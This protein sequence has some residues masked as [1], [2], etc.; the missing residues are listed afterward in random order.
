M[1]IGKG[2]RMNTDE[3]GS[4][5][6]AGRT[7]TGLLT[8]LALILP[9]EARVP[10]LRVFSLQITSVEVL[11]Y[12]A[13]LVW[14]I[15]WVAGRW[16]S[17]TVCHTCVGVFALV[18]LISALLAPFE[19]AAALKFALRSLG[20]CA[21]FYAAADLSGSLRLARRHVAAII[22]GASISAAAGCAEILSPRVAG[23]LG[24]FKTQPS[25]VGGYLR[26]SGTFQYANIGAMY[27]EAAVPLI[28]SAAFAAATG[29]GRRRTPWPLIAAMA[30][31]VEAILLSMSRAAELVS[32]VLLL[33]ILL[34]ARRVAAVPR[35][36]VL[37]C[38]LAL[39]LPL[40]CHLVLGPAFRLRLTTSEQSSWY[41]AAYSGNFG[42]MEMHPGQTM[43]LPVRIR[44]LGAMSWPSS[45]PRRITLSY[46][47][48]D[49]RRGG[50]IVWDGLRTPLPGDVA[51]GE[52]VALNARIQ[53]PELSGSCVLHLDLAQEG[54]TW[55][56]L[57][58][59]PS[60]EIPISLQGPASESMKSPEDFPL[61]RPASIQTPARRGLWRAALRMWETHPVFGVGPDNFRL[62]RGRFQNLGD[63]DRRVHSNNL[64]IEMLA[65][66]GSL[67]LLSFMAILL[68]I[69]V[70][71]RRLWRPDSSHELK[72]L[73]VG[74]GGTLAAFCL[75]GFVDYFFEFT[76]TY[77]LFWLAAGIV[78]GLAGSSDS[79]AR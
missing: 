79:E 4:R 29:V 42:R 11:L 75:H 30:L 8:C 58:G 63:F 77:G 15:G 76:P 62:V 1:I 10:V 3:H 14:G 34:F 49:P 45:G 51:P 33:T 40:L 70:K 23:W 16:R 35:P 2:P 38:A 20:G 5:G 67:G 68:S 13:L 39:S 57:E 41:V 53:A 78:A 61:F 66:L 18:V 17:W 50:F 52:E 55:F 37:F 69:A 24:V 19:R 25:M 59:S 21:L 54:A 56:S 44:N 48:G 9:F 12:S 72:F 28:L 27:W 74:L 65:N 26:A 47:W 60:V 6:Y 64:Y 46:H 32:V 7:A 71:L 73:I 31:I 22:A 36:V 43:L